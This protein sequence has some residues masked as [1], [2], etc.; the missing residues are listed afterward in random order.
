MKFWE[1]SHEV[2]EDFEFV[3]RFLRNHPELEPISIELIPILNIVTITETNM[4]RVFLKRIRRDNMTPQEQLDEWVKGNSIHNEERNECCPDFSCCCPDLLVSE[5]DRK[6]FSNGNDKV[7]EFLM[8]EFLGKLIKR[9][10]KD[11][12]IISEVIE[13]GGHC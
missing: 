3:N 9:Q 6:L 4:L 13:E 8:M 10:F 1:L 2:F 7:R 11:V 12:T 5:E